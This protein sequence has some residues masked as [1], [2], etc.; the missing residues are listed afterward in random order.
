MAKAIQKYEVPSQSIVGDLMAA[1]TGDIVGLSDTQT[2][3]NK[4]LTAP[5]I[6]APAITGAAT[7]ADGATITTPA[8]TFDYQSLASAG[9][10]IGDAGA[11]TATA[12]GLILATGADATKGIILPTAAA[13]KVYVVKNADAAN[14]VLK[15]YPQVNSTINALSANTAISM[16]ANTCAMFCA[17]SATNWVTCPLLPS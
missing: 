9:N 11:V 12:P 2:L 16:A 8:L 10:A 14:A 1:P 6:T 5:T 17:T 4:T 3:T 13:G 7:I 15:V